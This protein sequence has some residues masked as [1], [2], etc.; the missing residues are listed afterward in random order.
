MTLSY[1]SRCLSNAT[2]AGYFTFL[3]RQ[4]PLWSWCLYTSS[5]GSP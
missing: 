1:Q 3:R 5:C 2:I 4:L